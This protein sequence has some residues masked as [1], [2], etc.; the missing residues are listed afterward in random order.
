VS[1]GNFFVDFTYNAAGYML[2][3]TRSNGTKTSYTYNKDN[4][5]VSIEHQASNTN[6]SSETLS[7]SSGIINGI[8]IKSPVSIS[9]QPQS[10]SG[11]EINQLNQVKSSFE[12]YSLTYD[13]DGN[14]TNMTKNANQVFLASYTADNKISS[15]QADGQ[16]TQLFYDGMHY[17]RKII[18]G[19][20]TQ[21]LFYDHRGR[22]LFETDASGAV[23]KN[24]IYKGKRLI[25]MQTGDNQAC[26]YHCNRLGHIVAITGSNGAIL[27]AYQYSANGEIIGESGT[28]TNR[29]TFLGAFGGIRLNNSYILT[30]ARVY[31]TI[32]G[33]YIQR[34]PL[35]MLTGTNPY[36]YAANNP[37]SGIDPLGLDDLKTTVNSPFFDPP[38]DNS[39]GNAGG[40]ANPYAD[41]LPQRA[42]D[43]D[44]YGPVLINTIDDISNH[45]VTDLLPKGIGNPI[46][47][48][49]AINKF[50][51]KD[52]GGGLWQ[53]LPFNNSLEAIGNYMIEEGKN[54]KPDDTPGSGGIPYRGFQQTSPCNL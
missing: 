4:F 26:F 10:L 9:R 25:A 14:M 19:G 3:E 40:T 11:V 44:D 51:E 31:Q 8:S 52:F 46:S 39:Y 27:N 42:N 7:V 37:V 53:L 18:S 41:D 6:F 34:D 38:S 29:F 24:Y 47:L 2:T 22:L 15:I 36:L 50:A 21:N 49:K 32:T 54:I 45:P 17:P 30:G 1:W 23:V 13:A 43:W 33:R 16:T 5:P 12:G 48:F 20:N 28:Q 35:G